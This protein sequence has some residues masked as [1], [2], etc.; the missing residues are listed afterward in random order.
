M[1]NYLEMTGQ[2]EDGVR[3]TTNAETSG[4]YHTDWLNMIYPR[5]KLAKNLLSEDGIIFV[6]IDDI[7]AS[8]L[9][10]I[11][12]EI[13]GKENFLAQFVWRTDGNFDNQ[14]KI[15]TVMNIYY[16]MQKRS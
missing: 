8:K 1:K 3:I 6:S 9:K 10:I 14:A 12:D 5:L 13:F 4:R 11:M 2:T 15:K 7:E 16:Y